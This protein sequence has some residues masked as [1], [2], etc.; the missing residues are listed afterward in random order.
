MRISDWSS[1]VCSSDLIVPVHHVD[2]SVVEEAAVTASRTI[3]GVQRKLL[4]WHDGTA[5]RPS[6]GP[7]DP[8]T[9]IAKFNHNDEPPLVQNDPLSLRQDGRAAGWEGVC[10]SE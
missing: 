9:P 1:D 10:Q 7:G 4:A 6:V 5:F 3:S 2:G 8:A